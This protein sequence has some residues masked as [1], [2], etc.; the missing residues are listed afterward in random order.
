MINSTKASRKRAAAKAVFDQEL[1]ARI[2]RER[3]TPSDEQRRQALYL[4]CVAEAEAETAAQQ[5]AALA[6]VSELEKTLGAD[7]ERACRNARYNLT[8][9]DYKYFLEICPPFSGYTGEEE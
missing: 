1:H 3:N 5:H 8:L 9:P 4:S 2:D 6:P 7:R